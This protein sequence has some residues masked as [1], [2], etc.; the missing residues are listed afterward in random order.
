MR[1]W[2]AEF[3][4]KAIIL[5]YDDTLRRSA[6]PNP[7]PEEKSQIEILPGR[8]AELDEYAAQGYLLLG[9]SNQSAVEKKDSPLTAEKATELFRHTN[10]L[11]GQDIDFE[12]CPHH[13]FPVQCYCRKPHAGLGAHFI[14]KYKLDPS[15]CIMVGDQ[16]SDKTFARR[17]GFQFMDADEFF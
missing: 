4:N 17:C 16:T 1:S 14:W 13:R 15:Q 7:W 2:P 10:K 11:L 12:F 6:G 8:R 9:V 5:D 3:E